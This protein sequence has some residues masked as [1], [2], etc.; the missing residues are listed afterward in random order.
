MIWYEM[1]YFCRQKGEL[2]S[3]EKKRTDPDNFCRDM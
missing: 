1:S 3:S 2:I